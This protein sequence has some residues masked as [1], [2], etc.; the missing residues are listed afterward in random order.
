MRNPN[1]RDY[2]S[3]RGK[4]RSQTRWKD[5]LGRLKGLRGNLKAALGDGPKGQ[6]Q[7]GMTVAAL[8]AAQHVVEKPDA[9]KVLREVVEGDRNAAYQMQARGLGGILRKAPLR[10]HR[11][12]HFGMCEGRYVVT[13][14]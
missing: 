14:R 9:G 8:V 2:P 10:I 12:L 3:G 6:L 11:S 1:I 5:A 13:A 7:P 4:I